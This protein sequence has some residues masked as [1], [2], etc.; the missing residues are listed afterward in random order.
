MKFSVRV[1]APSRTL[2]FCT[3]FRVNVHHHIVSR[4]YSQDVRART[5]NGISVNG[6]RVE[7]TDVTVRGVTAG[8]SGGY[9]CQFLPASETVANN[10]NCTTDAW[11]EARR[12]LMAASTIRRVRVCATQQG[13]TVIGRDVVIDSNDVTLTTKTWTR[14]TQVCDGVMACALSIHTHAFS[15]THTHTHTHIHTYIHTYTHQH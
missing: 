1:T 2:T 13:I 12:L 3:H 8:I 11:C 5:F 14:P 6:E 4:R 9:F 7:I 15:H 10:P